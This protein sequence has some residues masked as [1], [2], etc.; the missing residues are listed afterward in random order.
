[1][2]SSSPSSVRWRLPSYWLHLFCF[3]V[4][5]VSAHEQSGDLFKMIQQVWDETRN[6]GVLTG[7]SE[8]KNLST[9]AGDVGLIPWVRK[10]KGMA[11]HSIILAWEFPWTEGLC[12][13]QSMGL[14]RVRHY[15][16]T[17]QQQPPSRWCWCCWSTDHTW[18][19]TLSFIFQTFRFGFP[20]SVLTR[21]RS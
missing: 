5:W 12:G 15:W 20:L 10:E 18:T 17:I 16:A 21:E 19:T 13:L 9:S 11:T 4:F 7:G 6:C 3:L 14:Q 2:S 8:V 1:M